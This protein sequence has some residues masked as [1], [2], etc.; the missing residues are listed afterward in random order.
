MKNWTKLF[1]QKNTVGLTNTNLVAALAHCPTLEAAGW[2]FRCGECHVDAGTYTTGYG[3]GWHAHNEYQIEIVASGR[4]EFRSKE[5]KTVSLKAGD[6]LI[7][8]WKLPHRWR[9]LQAGAMIGLALELLP[10]VASIR[11]QGWLVDDIVAVRHAQNRARIDEFLT[12]AVSRTRKPTHAK[13]LACQLFLIIADIMSAYLPED[14]DPYANSS[15]AAQA[16]GVEIV[17]WVMNHL[18]KNIGTDV[19]LED[20]ASKVGIS[21]RHLH[22]LFQKHVGKSLHNYW[23]DY[24]LNRAL[25]LLSEEGRQRQVKDIAYACSF[26]SLAYFSNTFRKVYG[27]TPSAMRANEIQMKNRRSSTDLD[28]DN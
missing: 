27:I 22:R 4:F 3:W 18:E 20:V 19:R 17:G 12:L 9:C 8:P 21:S 1:S 13:V 24:R 26:N 28:E 16:R 14:D 5:G 11:Q 15:Q 2:G 10:S 23:L 25:D 7:V 6:A